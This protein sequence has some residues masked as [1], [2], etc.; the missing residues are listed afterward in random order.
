MIDGCMCSIDQTIHLRKMISQHLPGCFSCLLQ[1]IQYI[2]DRILLSKIFP[3]ICTHCAVL[4]QFLHKIRTASC[5]DLRRKL[6]KYFFYTTYICRHSHD[7]LIQCKQDRHLNQKLYTASRRRYAVFCINSFCLLIHCHHR[8]F[9]FFIF[10]LLSDR[11][12]LRIHLCREF[13]EFLLLDGKRQ[14]QKINNNRK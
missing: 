1:T 12:Q 2:N 9:I 6:C 10:I 8:S 14:H 11:S 5:K 3:N 7:Y 4:C 13:R